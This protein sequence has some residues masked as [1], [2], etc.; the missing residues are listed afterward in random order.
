MHAHVRVHACGG[1][2]DVF[3]VLSL[4]RL[5]ITQPKCL[6]CGA[7]AAPSDLLYVSYANAPGGVLPYMLMLDRQSKSVVLAV[8]GTGVWACMG[9]LGRSEALLGLEPKSRHLRN[10]GW[11]CLL[12]CS[13]VRMG[14]ISVCGLTKT[15]QR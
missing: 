6:P 10:G 4:L 9:V 5:S 15:W 2:G 11:K 14:T 1:V 12:T 3:G 7:G 13:N 8:R